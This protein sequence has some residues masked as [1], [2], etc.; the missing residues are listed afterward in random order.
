MLRTLGTVLAALLLAVTFSACQSGGDG[1][2]DGELVVYSGRSQALVDSLVE[3]YRAQSD[4]NIEIRYGTDSQL[5]AALQEEGDQSEADVFWANTVGALSNAVNN[6]LLATLPDSLNETP[7][8]FAST[9]GKWVPVTTRFRVLAYNTDRV[10][11][12][13][14]PASI[15]ELPAADQFEGRIG[16]TPAYSSFQDFVTAL[17]VTKGDSTARAWLQGMKEL[18]PKGYTSNTP[19]IQAL[20]AG[21]IDIA[22]TNHYYVL[23]IQHDAPEG[24]Y[25][26]GEEEG[27]ENEASVRSSAPVATYHFEPGDVGN[28]ALVTGAGQLQTADR[29][30][31]AQDFIR[32]LL[33]QEAQS[34]AADRVNE[35]PVIEDTEVPPYLLD[36]NE[37]LTLSPEFDLE[38][39][40]EIDATLNMLREEDLL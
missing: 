32:F 24:E 22:L 26:E 3:R 13:A 1:E 21:E 15:T 39:L 23:R 9:S 8:R 34:Y 6:D 5:L 19:M 12:T 4:A 18:N 28:L 38:R 37:A 31:A 16:W 27:E 30:E 25:E 33:S 2:E 35:Y 20:A 17:R 40:R 29:P 14:L 36:A 11:S 10:D 7:D